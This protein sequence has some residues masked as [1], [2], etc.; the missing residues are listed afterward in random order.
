[1]TVEAAGDAERLLSRQ[2]TG[3]TT[4]ARSGSKTVMS[5]PVAPLTAAKGTPSLG[6][7]Q[8]LVPVQFVGPVLSLP[9]ARAATGAGGPLRGAERLRRAR[10]RSGPGQ[11][12]RSWAR[13]PRCGRSR[14]SR[15]EDRP[16]TASLRSRGRVWRSR[17]SRGDDGVGHAGASR[18]RAARCASR[19]RPSGCGP[20]S[21]KCGGL[22]SLARDPGVIA[23]EPCG[24]PRLLDERAAQIV[25]GDLPPKSR[26]AR[27]TCRSYRA[28]AFPAAT[29][30]FVIDITDEGLERAAA[31]RPSDFASGNAANLTRIAYKDNFSDSTGARHRRP[32]ERRLSDRRPAT[33]T[34][35]P[36]PT[37]NDAV[38]DASGFNYGLGIAPRG[39][40]VEDLLL[41]QPVPGEA[42]SRA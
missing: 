18:G 17:R 22:R 7:A 10:R 11:P 40:R 6:R 4:C 9:S 29:F 16:R 37:G 3:A 15:P 38:E 24:F 25:G 23:I 19:S 41:Q 5:I 8:G 2:Q 12:L 33:T 20:S 21:S 39:G 34:A 31:G 42:G 1:M 30:D 26:A 13:I 14:C 32:D 36:D 35:E 28:R 27:D